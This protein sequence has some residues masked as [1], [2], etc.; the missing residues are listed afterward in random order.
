MQCAGKNRDCVSHILPYFTHPENK[1]YSHT[2]IYQEYTLKTTISWLKG[3]Q[4]QIWLSNYIP[5]IFH[6]III[7]IHMK[8]VFLQRA[9]IT[10][11]WAGTSLVQ[12]HSSR[13]A[14]GTAICLLPVKQEV[15][16]TEEWRSSKTTATLPAGLHHQWTSSA[17][18]A[19][20]A[21]A[22]A[23]GPQ[24]PPPPSATLVEVN[25]S[26]VVIGRRSL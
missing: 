10:E 21:A 16:T 15:L 26:A 6:I 19:V 24:P 3:K 2:I 14:A 25:H 9:T 23:V 20:V 12:H 7:I 17:A 4:I 18:A 22:E 11:C 13:R 1:L 8:L 5:I